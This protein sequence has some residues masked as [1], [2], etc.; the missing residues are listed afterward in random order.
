MAVHPHLRVA[1]PVTNLTRSIDLYKRGLGLS[2]IGRFT[3]HEGFDGGMLGMV[4]ADYHFE[5]VYYRKHPVQP[6]PTAEDLT[7]FYIPDAAEWE[8]RCGKMI[9]AGFLEVDSF[10]PYWAERGRT[11]QD[12]DGYR[13]VLERASW[14]SSSETS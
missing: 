3:D 2:L 14:G 10:N 8:E 6:N 7:V 11:F 5:F 13:I 9:D 4:G 1:R 12:P